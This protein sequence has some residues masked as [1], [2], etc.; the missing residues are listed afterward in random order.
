MMPVNTFIYGTQG[1]LTTSNFT[2]L[3]GVQGRLLPFDIDLIFK[4]YFNAVVDADL[5][6][7]GTV[8]DGQFYAGNLD[9]AM[10]IYDGLVSDANFDAEVDQDILMLG[11]VDYADFITSIDDVIEYLGIVDDAVDAA[12]VESGKTVSGSVDKNVSDAEVDNDKDVNE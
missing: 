7:R 2:L 6:R 12:D 9:D 3:Y 5:I 4:L 10:Q 8:D 1:R 11:D